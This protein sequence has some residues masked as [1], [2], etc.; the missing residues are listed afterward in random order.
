M[1]KDLFSLLL[2]FAVF[3]ILSC[4]N[5]IYDRI[6]WEED[7]DGWI[8]FSSNN[9]EDYGRNY[10]SG[11]EDG[12]PDPFSNFELQIKKKSGSRGSAFRRFS[13]YS[14]RR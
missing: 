6:L 4:G 13:G 11:I 2:I 8:Q 14:V 5:T 12:M 10:Y 1:R 3:S 9:P 7:S